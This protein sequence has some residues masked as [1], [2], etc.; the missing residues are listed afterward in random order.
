MCILH[1]DERF[2][3]ANVES[4]CSDAMAEINWEKSLINIS[5]WQKQ[6]ES[7]QKVGQT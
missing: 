2:F 1:D 4:S 5:E 3:L 7:N 6:K